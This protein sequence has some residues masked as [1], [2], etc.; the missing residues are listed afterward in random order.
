MGAF[1]S[2]EAAKTWADRHLPGGE[3]A[4]YRED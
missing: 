2:E 4:P 1:R 3:W